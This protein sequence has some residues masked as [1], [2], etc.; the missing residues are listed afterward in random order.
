MCDSVVALGRAALLRLSF[1]FFLFHQA[2]NIDYEAE[3]YE[4]SI[5]ES[6]PSVTPDAPQGL[7]RLD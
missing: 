7:Q 5:C 6:A 3:A 2:V 4:F 1:F